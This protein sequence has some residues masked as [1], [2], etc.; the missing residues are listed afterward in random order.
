[1]GQR[2]AEISEALENQERSKITKHQKLVEARNN[3][4]LE[5]CGSAYTLISSILTLEP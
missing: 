4:P 2:G 5:K 1:M 3:L